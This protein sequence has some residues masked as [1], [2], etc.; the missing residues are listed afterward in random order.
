M[1]SAN[2][3]QTNTSITNTR[4]KPKSK[5]SIP[6]NVSDRSR[7]RQTRFVVPDN[8]GNVNVK[9]TADLHRLEAKEEG[10]LRCKVSNG[11]DIANRLA[12]FPTSQ[13]T[14]SHPYPKKKTSPVAVVPPG[15]KESVVK[16]TNASNP[17]TQS[18]VPC[19]PTF[20]GKGMPACY[21]NFQQQSNS[22]SIEESSSSSSADNGQQQAPHLSATARSFQKTHQQSRQAQSPCT[23]FQRQPQSPLIRPGSPLRSPRIRS[24]MFMNREEK[25]QLDRSQ[26]QRCFSPIV[27]PP[28]STMNT[29]GFGTAATGFRSPIML[30]SPVAN[31]VRSPLNHTRMSVLSPRQDDVSLYTSSKLNKFSPAL[32]SKIGD[33]NQSG[34]SLSF[35]PEGRVLL[36]LC[37]L[38]FE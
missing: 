24:P 7:S 14:T 3:S 21:S 27:P 15:G 8:G 29:I 16:T 12:P 19:P 1:I 23:N 28:T 20:A 32:N 36:I 33:L 2:N 17:T 11:K 26:R 10:E 9:S 13:A 37:D 4:P 34:N 25:D 35:Q 31:A 22:N 30:R 6:D 38:I 18:S 5:V